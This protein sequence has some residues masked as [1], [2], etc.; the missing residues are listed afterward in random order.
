M[1][2]KARS[3]QD[4]VA[5]PDDPEELRHNMEEHREELRLAVDELRVAAKKWTDPGD[6]V[7]EHPVPWLVGA[8]AVGL[9]L[10]WHR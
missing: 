7:R 2:T 9:W 3:D 4:T 6:I 10:G 8:L 5:R 1:N